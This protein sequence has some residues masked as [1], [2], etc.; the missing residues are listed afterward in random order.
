MAGTRVHI[1]PR[2]NEALFATGTP[3]E[4][5]KLGHDLRTVHSCAIPNIEG[6]VR[7]CPHAVECS[8]RMFG[9]ADEGG[10]GPESAEPGT[11]GQ[12]PKYVGYYL[13]TQEG[14][15]KEDFIRCSA[16]M[17]ALFNRYVDQ[18]K[19]G[20]TLLIVAQEGEPIEILEKVPA[21]PRT[22]NKSNNIVLLEEMKQILVPVHPRPEELDRRAGFRKGAKEAR[23][24]RMLQRRR[25]RAGF[26][27][28]PE[29][30]DA[31]T[32]GA[33]AAASARPV[34]GGT[35]GAG[36]KPVARPVEGGG[37]GKANA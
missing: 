27:D 31:D 3:A 4:L 29:P 33:G 22:C 10:F 6:G 26:D 17:G 5:R 8:K 7:G 9:I 11:P 32:K 20:E 36:A 2:I 21:E 35:K 28:A 15:E 30:D 37:G 24:Q 13:Q 34:V 18:E 12:G 14:D 16:W 25:A 19:T 1:G 23:R